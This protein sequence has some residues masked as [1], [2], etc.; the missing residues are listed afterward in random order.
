MLEYYG[1]FLQ[2]TLAR[3]FVEHRIFKHQVL[4]SDLSEPGVATSVLGASDI[5]MSGLNHRILEHLVADLNARSGVILYNQSG[6]SRT[7]EL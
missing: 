3:Q 4:V 7:A 1:I 6:S 2:G 5:G